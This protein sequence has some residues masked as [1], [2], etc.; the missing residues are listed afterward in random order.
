VAGRVL[1]RRHRRRVDG[2]YCGHDV[3]HGVQR[4]PDPWAGLDIAGVV[5]VGLD[6]VAADVGARGHF[7]DAGGEVHLEVCEYLVGLDGPVHHGD[8]GAGGLAV[9]QVGEAK[10][11]ELVR[12]VG[13]APA[14][15]DN[16]RHDAGPEERLG[17]RRL[18]E[19]GNRCRRVQSL[20]AKPHG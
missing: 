19:D 1:P 11:I 6:H 5:G 12:W 3:G 17:I 10:G 14:Q 2:G 7:L 15:H 16:C 13:M 20:I 8:H 9:I 4:L 18:V